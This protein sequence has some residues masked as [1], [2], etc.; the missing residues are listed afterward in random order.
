MA[1]I[2]FPLQ[3]YNRDAW[4]PHLQKAFGDLGLYVWPD[5]PENDGDV[6]YVIT[7]RA[8]KIWAEFP[9][10]RAIL[11]LSA[12]VN[13]YVGHPD[14]PDNIPLIRMIEDG[15][16]TG[17]MEYVVANVMFF[18][19]RM[20]DFITFQQQNI[21]E[22]GDQ[23]LPKLAREQRVGILGL[24]HLGGVCARHLVQ[25]GFQV[26]GWS[27]SKKDIT[28]ITSHAGA[29]EL[30]MFLANTDILVNLLPLTP[31]TR[32]IINRDFLSKLP[33]GSYVINAARGPHIVD[34]DL[35][36][37]IDNGHIAAAA[38]DVFHT[39]PLPADHP[40]WGHKRVFITPHIAA[41]TRPDT[42][43]QS[44]IRSIEMLD[45]GQMPDG[46]VKRDRAY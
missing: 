42:G 29:G 44:L 4:L 7:V 40:F 20:P 1:I 45:K 6:E 19:R 22:I 32:G 15:L 13:Q 11:S 21:W 41:L 5:R 2:F 31:D 16:D 3:D 8:Q 46:F 39:E 35:I 38:L 17:M 10:L 27:N 37:M 25:L 9:N 12:G 30:D 43:T 26:S 24:G 28:G 14:M 34:D 33:R 23:Y 18:H 36:E